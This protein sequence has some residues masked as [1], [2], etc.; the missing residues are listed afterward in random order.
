VIGGREAVGINPWGRV[1]ARIRRVLLSLSNG[2]VGTAEVNLRGLN[3][4]RTLVLVN[5]D[6]TDR[7]SLQTAGA[8]GINIISVELVDSV[9]VLAGGVSS[10]YGAD[11]I[12]GRELS[13]FS[14]NE[15]FRNCN[16]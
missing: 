4:T 6:R 2:S 9:H 13:S 5:G 3:S 12:A 7:G 15:V 16:D 8:S 11:A 10:V 14:I 1:R